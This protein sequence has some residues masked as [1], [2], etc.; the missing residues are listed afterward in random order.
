MVNCYCNINQD[1]DPIWQLAS[2]LFLIFLFIV[3][4]HSHAAAM[5]VK[6][7]LLLCS[8]RSLDFVGVH[9]LLRILTR[10]GCFGT[11]HWNPILG[12]HWC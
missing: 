1:L 8:G 5:I 10:F 11:F 7:F 6:D 9:D 2:F 3:L 12:L 4:S